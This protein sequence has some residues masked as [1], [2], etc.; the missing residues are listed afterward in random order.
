MA[1]EPER[2]LAEGFGREVV[3]GAERL[4]VPVLAFEAVDGLEIL[5]LAREFDG[6]FVAF[7]ERLRSIIEF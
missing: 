4:R 2:E 1:V 3:D 5:A 7:A 6:N